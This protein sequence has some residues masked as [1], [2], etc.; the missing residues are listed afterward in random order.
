V[1]P[2]PEGSG[3]GDLPPPSSIP[4]TPTDLN[5]ERVG[6]GER[7]G[8][9]PK[10]LKRLLGGRAIIWER[11]RAQ[12][13]QPDRYPDTNQRKNRGNERGN[14]MRGGRSASF[15]LC[16]CISVPPT[17]PRGDGGPRQEEVAPEGA[18][19]TL[20][21]GLRDAAAESTSAH[22]RRGFCQPF[23]AYLRQDQSHAG[24]RLGWPVALPDRVLVP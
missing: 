5:I 12:V 18:A 14:S 24:A 6:Q 3:Y 21:R 15:S 11:V 4:A 19:T 17:C 22:V 16:L 20:G 13:G 8:P 23:P 2:R 1:H 9:R 10:E 7:G